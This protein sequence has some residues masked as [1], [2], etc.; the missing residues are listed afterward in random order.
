MKT[1]RLNAVTLG[2]SDFARSVRFYQDLGFERRFKATG[3]EIAFFDAGG[4][5][6]SLFR[7]DMLAGDAQLPAMPRPPAFRGATFAQLCQTDAEVDALMSKALA[8]GATLLKPA[9]KTSF[10][11][12]S[13]YFADPDGHAWEAVRASGFEFT[14]DGRV[15]LPD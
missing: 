2:V 1:P 14:A 7:W 13:G 8:A 11:G 4:L 6:L 15:T 3:D 12:Y 9:Q 5:V 10:G